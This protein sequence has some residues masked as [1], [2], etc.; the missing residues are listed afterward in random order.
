MT[1]ASLKQ[2]QTSGPELSEVVPVFEAVV[3]VTHHAAAKVGRIRATT[4]S[5]N[6]AG[7]QRQHQ[8]PGTSEWS[9]IAREPSV[10]L[11]GNAVVDHQESADLAG[12]FAGEDPPGYTAR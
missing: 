4:R 8:R 3:C 5:F 2:L 12:R 6:R 11:R 1:Q 10:G 7:P 9:R